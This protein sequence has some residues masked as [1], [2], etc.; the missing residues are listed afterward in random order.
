MSVEVKDP[1]EDRMSVEVKNLGGDCGMS[2]EV[3]DL[4]T[5]LACI[6]EKE[7]QLLETDVEVD[8]EAELSGVYRHIGAG[9]TVMR[10]TKI[11]PA[12]LFHKVK[13][14]EGA[15]VLIGLLA[16]RERVGYLMGERPENLGF[17]LNRAVERPISPVMVPPERA[18]CQEV[19]HRADEPG[20]DIRKLIPAPTNTEEDAGPYITM[21]M[22]YGTRRSGWAGPCQSR[23]A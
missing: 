6:R 20:F 4:R 8:P 13:G 10:P 12:M 18:V 15:S 19:V 7:G 16:S 1:G 17:L 14:H 23:S 22:C 5:A 2:V 11:G 9:G 3:K 21:G